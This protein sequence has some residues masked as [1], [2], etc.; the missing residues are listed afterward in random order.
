M[1]DQ[2]SAFPETLREPHS[3]HC[4]ALNDATAPCHCG[5]RARNEALVQSR[6]VMVSLCGYCGVRGGFFHKAN[7]P[8]PGTGTAG[9]NAGD[10]RVAPL[11]ASDCREA[12]GGVQLS[13]EYLEVSLG[14]LVQEANEMPPDAEPGAWQDLALRFA[15]C[16]AALERP[17]LAPTMARVTL[18]GRDDMSTSYWLLV[19]RPQTDW[20]YGPFATEGAAELFALEHNIAGVL[21]TGRK[22]GGHHPPRYDGTRW[23]KYGEPGWTEAAPA[24]KSFE[25]QAQEEVDTL[26]RDSNDRAS[27]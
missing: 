5:A 17:R 27:E 2:S 10:A 11:E 18:H 22:I 25:Q 4:P 13:R 21:F 24:L 19:H 14:G 9:T 15:T 26:T 3:D 20:H 12:A 1:T 16:V 7:C 23:L 8:A 6:M